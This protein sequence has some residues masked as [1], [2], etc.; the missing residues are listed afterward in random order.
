MNIKKLVSDTV[1]KHSLVTFSSSE[2]KNV[3]R[4]SG[5]TIIRFYRNEKSEE[6]EKLMKLIGVYGY[7]EILDSFTYSKSDRR[8]VFINGEIADKNLPYFLALE[9]CNVIMGKKNQDGILGQTPEERILASEFAH[10]ICNLSKHGLLYRFLE[11]HLAGTVTVCVATMFAVICLGFT[12]ILSPLNDMNAVSEKGIPADSVNELSFIPIVSAE[13]RLNET[14]GDVTEPLVQDAFAEVKD[15]IPENIPEVPGNNTAKS[16]ETSITP[17]ESFVV[18]TEQRVYYSTKSGKKY[19]IEGCSYIKGKETV[20]LTA[21]D[22][23]SKGY[24][25]CS[26]CFK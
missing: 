12:F 23:E 8:I 5:Y 21:S 15:P 2:L 6:T 11:Y 16:P 7:S 14:A 17:S 24:E 22:I 9:T 4:A 1:D 18:P 3:I 13:D 20:K 19:H 26:R 25:P 10:R